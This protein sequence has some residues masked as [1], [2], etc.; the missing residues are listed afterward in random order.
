MRGGYL[1]PWTGAASHTKDPMDPLEF[2]LRMLV[3][4]VAGC[5][6]GLAGLGGSIIMIPALA[7]FWGYE[8]EEAKNEHHVYMAA[9]MCVNVIVALSS[10]FLHTKK[11]AA[12]KDLLMVLIP[13][14]VAGM[15]IGVTV[16]S[17]NKG[18]WALYAF[19]GF[20]WLYCLYNVITTIVKLPDYPDDTPTPAWWKVGA[21]GLF[22]GCV[23]GYLGIGGGILLVP[24]LNLAK[25]PLRH[26]IA[27]SAGAMWVASLIGATGKLALLP[28]I[29]LP[30]GTQLRIMDAIWFAIPMGIG[31]LVGAYLGAFLAHKLRLPHLKLAIAFILAIASVKMVL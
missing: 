26:A 3:G 8:D 30:D 31:A 25:L 27:G 11:K 24:L 16:S 9:A 14:M 20:I 23:A 18:A 17:G 13:A 7:M 6:G 2:S 1:A 29:Y 5:V 22:A 15:L 10:T 12:R 19:A 28:T 21:V 4:F